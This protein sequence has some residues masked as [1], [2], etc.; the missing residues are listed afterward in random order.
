MFIGNVILIILNLPFVGLFAKVLKTPRSILMP[1]IAMFSIIGAYTINGSGFDVF[2]ILVF[3]VVGYIL[4]KS[5]FPLAP[6]ILGVVLG[7]IDRNQF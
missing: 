7:L 4:R 6:L 3:G 5:E 2:L 1:V